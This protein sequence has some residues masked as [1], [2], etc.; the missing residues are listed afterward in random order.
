MEFRI[1]ER[2]RPQWDRLRERWGDAE[3]RRWLSELV[4][5]LRRHDG[6]PPDAAEDVRGPV[7]FYWLIYGGVYAAYTIHDSPPPPRGWW[8]A[9]RRLALWRQGRTRRVIFSG[10]DLPGYPASPAPPP[11]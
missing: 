9:L 3:A 8:D 1:H 7:M 11:H 4:A 5:R 6:I 2:A 10:L